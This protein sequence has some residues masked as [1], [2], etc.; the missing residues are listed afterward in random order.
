MKKRKPAFEII[1]MRGNETAHVLNGTSIKVDPKSNPLGL[2][3]MLGTDKIKMPKGWYQTCVACPMQYSKTVRIGKDYYEGY[4]RS[5]WDSD[6][7]IEVKM[8]HR[9]WKV[10]EA[11]GKSAVK[12]WDFWTH[13]PVDKHTDNPPIK[14]MRLINKKFSRMVKEYDSAKH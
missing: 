13:E 1:P 12:Q 10:R 3:F 11:M 14:S 9:N 5:R 6:F 2:E 8:L 4:L 7:R